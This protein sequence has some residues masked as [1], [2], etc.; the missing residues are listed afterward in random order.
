[1]L[2][3]IT[4]ARPNLIIVNRFGHAEADGGGMR[5]EIADAVCSGAVVLLA[6]RFTYLDALKEILGGPP[7]LLRSSAAA[8]AD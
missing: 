7:L 8:V 4:A 1:M 6:A 3:R 5:P 2:R